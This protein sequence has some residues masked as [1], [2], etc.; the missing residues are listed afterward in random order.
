MENIGPDFSRAR[1]A[2][3]FNKGLQHIR[4]AWC[5]ES[6]RIIPAQVASDRFGLRPTEYAGWERVGRLMN[7]N[8]G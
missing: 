5:D 7:V 6:A 1:A 3:L 2:E 4:H 8:G